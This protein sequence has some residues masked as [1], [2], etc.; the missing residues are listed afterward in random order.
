MTNMNLKPSA[1]PDL[2]LMFSLEELD[3]KRRTIRDRLTEIPARRE[4]LNSELAR[5]D[6][7]LRE[8]EQAVSAKEKTLSGLELDLK[9]SQTQESEKKVKLNSVKT[10]KEYDALKSE[11]ETANVERGKV[12]ERIL[13]LMDEISDLKV[14]LKREKLS[15]ETDKKNL[16]GELETQT[17][18]TQKL[19]VELKDLDDQAREK[20]R[21]MPD[22]IQREYTRLRAI[23]PEGQIL[24]RLVPDENLYSCTACNS[25]V[26]HQFVIDIKR[27]ISL[28]R[29]EIC[30]RLL[31]I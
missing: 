3:Q 28:H 27:G 13:L 12:E 1:V 17:A 22:D 31:Y 15:G 20:L 14:F 19:Q 23:Y 24:S 8:K 5:I 16:S 18:E 25:P 21:G 26:A 6:R 2:S 30:R 10:Q 11:I 29:C 9:T 4:H 7:S